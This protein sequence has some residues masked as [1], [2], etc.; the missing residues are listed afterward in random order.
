[1]KESETPISAINQSLNK[2]S[3]GIKDE[4]KI[5]RKNAIESMRKQLAESFKANSSP[6]AIKFPFETVKTVLKSILNALNDPMEKCRELSCEIIKLVLDY[7]N[8]NTDFWDNDLTSMLIMTLN[9]RL[10]GKEVK[11]TSEEIRL[12][13]VSLLYLLME[14]KSGQKHIFEAHFQELVSI[15]INSINDLYPEAKKKGCLCT[16]LLANKLAGSSFHMQSEQLVKPLLQNIVHQHSRVRK[17]I[18]ECLCDVIQ[19]GNN[20]SVT[21][22]ISHLAQRLFDQ[23]PQVRMAVI[24]LV[25]TWLL[26]LPDRYSFWSKLI[27]LLLTGFI[28]EAL[29]VK[30][31]TESLWWDVGIK[32]EKENDEELKDKASFLESD[33]SNYPAECKLKEFCDF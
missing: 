7:S 19:Y 13:L 22:A 14:S 25:G 29:E 32:Y 23:A 4:S 24:K 26:D 5:Q 31:L 9:Q 16:K 27:P 6:T 12:E 3:Q 1:M 30:E 17:D 21:D 33:L 20:K 2:F 11:E 18:I 15:L 28:D 10:G 8:S